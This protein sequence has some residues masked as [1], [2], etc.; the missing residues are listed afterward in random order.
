MKLVPLQL[1]DA[2]WLLFRRRRPGRHRQAII[3]LFGNFR[4]DIPNAWT[5]PRMNVS[6]RT[7]MRR[8]F[9]GATKAKVKLSDNKNAYNMSF[10]PFLHPA[11]IAEAVRTFSGP[12]SARFVRGPHPAKTLEKKVWPLHEYIR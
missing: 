10:A 3:S 12:P 2:S 11:T 1:D 8:V 6:G 4:R 7:P 5:V 9:P